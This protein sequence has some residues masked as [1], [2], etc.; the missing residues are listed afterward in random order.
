MRKAGK[1]A[2]CSIGKKIEINLILR[3]HFIIATKVNYKN[4]KLIFSASFMNENIVC[5]PEQY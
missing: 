1:N 3:E 5:D 2:N 4:W